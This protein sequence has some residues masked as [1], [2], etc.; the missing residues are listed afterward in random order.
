MDKFSSHDDQDE[1]FDKE[2]IPLDQAR[3][4]QIFTPH[5]LRQQVKSPWEIMRW[6]GRNIANDCIHHAF[7]DLSPQQ[8]K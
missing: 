6:F 7:G 2:F 3:A 8:Q 1:L 4:Q 5:S